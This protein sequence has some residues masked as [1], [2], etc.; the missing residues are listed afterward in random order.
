MN[1]GKD[2]RER[3]ILFSGEMVK[4]I[5][6][7]RKTETR[8]VIKPQPKFHRTMERLTQFVW[9]S[10]ARRG[11]GCWENFGE[12][13]CPHGKL[14]D[15]LWVRETWK[16]NFYGNSIIYKADNYWNEFKIYH[17]YFDE[18]CKW[19]TKKR[20]KKEWH[21][22]WRPSIFM[23][24]WASRINLEVLDIWV[25][26]IQD[27][28]EEGIIAEGF[29]LQ[30]KKFGEPIQY[31]VRKGF[32]ILWNKINKRRG[33]GWETNPWVFVVKFKRL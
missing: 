22:K 19:R 12:W 21:K 24:R 31:G 6:D 32:I 18:W 30:A 5:L 11:D 10:Y 16:T 17:K 7:G 25:E 3:P 27:I 29:A 1:K 8:R 33:Y 26:R 28:T 9:T 4:A 13:K 14:G 23:P 2:M 20:V 15:R